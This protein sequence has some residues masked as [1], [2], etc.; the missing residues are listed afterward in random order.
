MITENAFFLLRIPEER[1]EITIEVN[2]RKLLVK[3]VYRS[4]PKVIKNS[5]FARIIILKNVSNDIFLTFSNHC[6]IYNFVQVASSYCFIAE[7]KAIAIYLFAS[8]VK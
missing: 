5:I 3:I 4:Q 7:R 2:F 1:I 8:I 6:S